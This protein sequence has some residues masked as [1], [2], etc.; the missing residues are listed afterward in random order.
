[1]CEYGTHSK[2]DHMRGHKTGLNKSKM[3]DI[4]ST[5]CSDFN[6]MKLEINYKE[7]IGKKNTHQEYKQYATKQSVCH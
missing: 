5:I 7:K 1:M 6:T 2:I 4:I 3:I